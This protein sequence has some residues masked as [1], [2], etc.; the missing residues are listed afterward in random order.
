MPK[1]VIVLGS[2][3]SIGRA[4][5]DVA[6]GLRD[7]VA[8]I[9]L[10]ANDNWQLL[11]EQVRTSGAAYVALGNEQYYDRLK[12]VLPAGTQV[13]VGPDALTKI[14][15]DSGA[16]FV[17]NAVVGA[18]GLPATVTALERGLTVGLA[19]K[20]SLVVAGSLLMKLARERNARLIPVDSEHSAI[21]QAGLAGHES[22]VRRVLLTASGGPF[23]TWPRERIAQAT[24]AE[25]L[26]HPTWSMGP[27]ITID[28]AT[29]MN[30]ALEIIEAAHLFGLSADQIEVV[31]H[32]ESIVHS[33]VEF[34]DGSVLAQ[35]STPDMRTPIQYALT[36]PRRR[37]GLPTRLDWKQIRAL[38]FEPPDLERFPA[39]G[40]GFEAVRRGGSTGAVLNAANEASVAAFRA[41]RIRFGRIAELNAQVLQRHDPVAQPTLTQLLKLDDWARREV[42]ACLAC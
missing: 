31:V 9:G 13:I 19:N 5:L 21:L 29:M 38:N 3:G 30:K 17:L 42:Q 28:S 36:Y 16:D 37:N 41:G 35:L 24:L 23:R 4:T 25:A 22:E 27:K 33:M 15:H 14:V 11:A 2:T 34:C 6:A 20:E 1:R 40:L 12:A 32:P 7:E 26:Q 8:I 10:A 39:L 18:A